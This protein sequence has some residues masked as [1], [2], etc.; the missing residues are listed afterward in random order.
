VK[1][2][3]GDVHRRVGGGIVFGG[4]VGAG[5]K[6]LPV[7]ADDDAIDVDVPLAL[8]SASLIATTTPP[9]PMSPMTVTVTRTLN[10][11]LE[12]LKG[13]RPVAWSRPR[14]Q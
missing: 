10:G 13:G 5:A 6:R 12:S 2:V 4:D 14:Q 9:S 7:V 8:A 1:A 3:D 11:S